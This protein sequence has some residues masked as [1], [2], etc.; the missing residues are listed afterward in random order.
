MVREE[1]R[2]ALRSLGAG[3]VR[4]VFEYPCHPLGRAD[5]HA[6]ALGLPR[7]GSHFKELLEPWTK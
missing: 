6:D 2:Q 4:A 1:Q 5:V 7:A 3:L